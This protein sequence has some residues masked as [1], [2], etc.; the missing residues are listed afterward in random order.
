MSSKENKDYWN[1]WNSNYSDV[2]KA[3]GRMRMSMR[4]LGFIQCF[5][6]GRNLKVLDIGIGNGRIL[7]EILNSSGKDSI[8]YG[9]DISE[10]MVEICKDKFNSEPKLKKLSVCDLSSDQIPFDTDFNLVTMIRVL[11]YNENWSDIIS[12]IIMRMEIRGILIFTMPNKLSISILSGDKFSEKN[13]PILHASISQIRNLAAKNNAK[14]IQVCGFSKLPNFLYHLSNNHC[15]V[16]TL[17]AIER[18]L[19]KIL[20]K[21]FLGR[22]LFYAV[23]K[24]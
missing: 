20:G 6:N 9:V 13:L 2:W 11:K 15:Y 8:I 4:E 24:N 22:E 7:E 19:E 3:Y 5:I 14:L 16:N 23:Q 10:R 21:R 1:N 17:M 18:F 12:K